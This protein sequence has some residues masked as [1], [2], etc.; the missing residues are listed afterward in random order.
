MSTAHLIELQTKLAGKR[1]QVVGIA[2]EKGPKARER[3]AEAAQAV[4]ERGINYPVLVTTKGASCPVQKAL[5]VQFYPTLV[6]LDRNGRILAASWR[7]GNHP[8]AHGP[9]DRRRTP[10][11]G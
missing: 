2:C 9:R 8:G 7:N 5:E 3:Q 4:K 6:L 1:F 11:L 10:R